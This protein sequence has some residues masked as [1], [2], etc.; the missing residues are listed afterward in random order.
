MDVVIYNI[1]VNIFTVKNAVQCH[2]LQ[3]RNM[4]PR[5]QETAFR[6]SE[7]FILLGRPQTPTL[8]GL[9]TFDV[10]IS[11]NNHTRWV[12]LKA[13]IPGR[14]GVFIELYVLRKGQ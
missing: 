5:C 6:V 14:N 1:T 13:Q 9:R 3:A 11:K 4:C 7:L 8:S 2:N 12:S 10:H